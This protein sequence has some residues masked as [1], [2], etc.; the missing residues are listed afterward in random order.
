MALLILPSVT[1][2]QEDDQLFLDPADA[3]FEAEQKEVITRLRHIDTYVRI[4]ALSSGAVS[5]AILAKAGYS[6]ARVW[7]AT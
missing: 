1:A 3:G 4:S 5:V 6:F 7:M 2:M